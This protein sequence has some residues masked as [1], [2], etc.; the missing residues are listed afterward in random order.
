MIPGIPNVNIIPKSG[1]NASAGLIICSFIYYLEFLFSLN[2][3]VTCYDLSYPKRFQPD[4][5]PLS[6]KAVAEQR[7]L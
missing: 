3:L 5:P 2:R 7:K 4:I 1:T 6:F